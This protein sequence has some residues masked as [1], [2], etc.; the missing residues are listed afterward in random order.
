MAT[1]IQIRRDT[2]ANWTSVSPILSEGEFGY[3]TSTPALLKIGDGSTSWPGLPYLPIVQSD[4]NANWTSRVPLL[5]AGEMAFESDKPGIKIGDG[6]TTWAA[7]PLIAGV[8]KQSIWIPAAAISPIAETSNA[9]SSLANTSVSVA[10]RPDLVTLDFDGTTDEFGQFQIVMP[11][12]WD[13]GTVSFKAYW[14]VSTAVTT[15]VQWDLQGVALANSDSMVTAYGTL[16]SVTDTSLN[17]K[18]DLHATSESP[19]ITIA[20]TPLAG[21]ISIFRVG[22]DPDGDTMSQD[23][24]LIGIMIFYTNNSTRDD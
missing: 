14:T 7:L 12:Q 11:K 4:T 16:Q 21:E 10:A 3:E 15:T 20:G 5:A 23:A 18:N 1:K 22:R 9:C 24:R 6:S 17:A 13:E 2:K 8:G 19:S